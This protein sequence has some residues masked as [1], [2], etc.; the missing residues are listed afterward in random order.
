MGLIGA[1]EASLQSPVSFRAEDL[2]LQVIRSI[3][4]DGDGELFVSRKSA[5]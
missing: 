2:C 3:Q 5:S 4:C 1:N